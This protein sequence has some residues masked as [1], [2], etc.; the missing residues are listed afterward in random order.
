M[1]KL[2]YNVVKNMC[3]I[4]FLESTCREDV[5]LSTWSMAQVF[6]YISNVWIYGLFINYKNLRGIKT[7]L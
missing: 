1:I 3:R 7:I 5:T 2:K 6:A 4:L